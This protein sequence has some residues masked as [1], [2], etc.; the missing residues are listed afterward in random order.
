[1]KLKL[2]TLMAIVGA[3]AF[4]QNDLNYEIGRENLR[5]NMIEGIGESHSN[6]YIDYLGNHAKGVSL[7]TSSNLL[8][9][10]NIYAGISTNYLKTNK[11]NFKTRSYAFTYFLGYKQNDNIFIAN[12]SYM[13]KKNMDLD[14]N[15]KFYEK[16]INIGGEMGHVF[17]LQDIK[18]Y[19]FINFSWNNHIIKEYENLA[20]LNEKLFYS[21]FGVDIHKTFMDKI[22][23]G[24]NINYN[25]GIGE[26][27]KYDGK[28]LDKKYLSSNAYLGY[29]IDP[30]FMVKLG[31]HKI[32]NRDFH[33]NKV[34][35]GLNYYF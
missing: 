8:A 29:L 9:N 24:A 30:D 10:P 2:I 32:W 3:M 1:M 27:I 18:I 14:K 20:K 12:V 15:Y 4:A 13:Q 19:P 21:G 34:S 11:D 25:Y 16:N 33:N 31:I 35:F 28:T 23:V 7:G 5:L 26:K 6:Q 22:L 17:S